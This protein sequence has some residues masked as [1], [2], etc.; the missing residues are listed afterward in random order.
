MFQNNCSKPR[1]SKT[2]LTTASSKSSFSSIC[3]PEAKRSFIYKKAPTHKISKHLF[4][5]FQ[6]L[7]NYILDLIHLPIAHAPSAAPAT[8]AARAGET[9]RSFS[10]LLSDFHFASVSSTFSIMFLV[11]LEPLLPFSQSL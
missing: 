3:P 5:Y 4:K 1:Q 7:K 9:A 6:I 10:D 11:W 2:S 8:P